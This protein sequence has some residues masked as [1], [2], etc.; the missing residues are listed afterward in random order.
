MVACQTVEIPIQREYNSTETMFPQMPD[1]YTAFD[2][3]Y[4]SLRQEIA[5]FD[6]SDAG[7][8]FLTGKD[9]LDF[10]NR[11]S[12]N[13][14]LNLKKDDIRSTILITEKA[15]I[16]DLVTLIPYNN[17]YLLEIS[18]NNEAKILKWL[19]K[20]IIMEDVKITDI[21]SDFTKVS[22]TG[23]KVSSLTQYLGVF[24]SNA[25]RQKVYRIS[26][27][28]K[29][30]LVCMDSLFASNVW[31]IYCHRED[32]GDLLS[33][34]TSVSLP[35][36]RIR[37]IGKKVFETFR[38]EEG[39]PIV[40]K[41]LTEYVNPLEA[42]LRKIVSST[43]GCYI[44]QEV[45]ARLDT[46]DKLQ[47]TLTGFICTAMIEGEGTIHQGG[48]MVGWTTSY[49]FSPLLNQCLSLGYLKTDIPNEKL[50]LRLTNG[51]EH[52]VRTV[53]LPLRTI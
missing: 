23:N 6:R 51:I 43:K 27:A 25:T 35:G 7:F 32:F 49:C 47:R 50:I 4:Q 17:G 24:L 45:I 46:Y 20:Y 31:N 53:E 42:G 30:I 37:Q 29:E 44:G 11:L 39:V 2:E 18:P 28:K 9:V 52:P 13:D 38:I 34:L 22:I 33:E 26:L 3:E 41:E 19:D 40:G 15:K 48:N 16:I 14:V 5:V 1:V 10:L 21:T 8:L 36:L 12:T